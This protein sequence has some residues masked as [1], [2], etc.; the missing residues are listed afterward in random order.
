MFV[1]DDKNKA[2]KRAFMAY[3]K[4]ISGFVLGTSILAVVRAASIKIL[5]RLN[6]ETFRTVYEIIKIL[7]IDM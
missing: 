7:Q 5:L 3:T 4:M 6:G 1:K 2:V